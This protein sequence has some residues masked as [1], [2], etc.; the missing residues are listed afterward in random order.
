MIRYLSA[1]FRDSRAVGIVLIACTLVSLL[2]ANTIF[3]H[4]WLGFLETPLTLPFGHFPHTLLH[5]IN[6]GAMALFFFLAGLDIRKEI[7]T[8]ALSSIKKSMLPV[9][10]AAGGMLCPAFIFLLFNHGTEGVHGWGIPMATDIA[11]SLGILSLL[12]KRVPVEL[13]VFLTAL[14][15]IDDLG[16]ILTI[17]IFYT[18]QL[19]LY[20]LLGAAALLLLMA[21]LRLLKIK[22]LIWYVIPGL[23]L[24]YCIFNSGIHATIAGVLLAFMIPGKHIERLLH[25]LHF[26]VTFIIMPAFAL[27]NTAIVFPNDGLKALG[28]M[29]SCGLIAGL[30][31]GKP[32]GIMSFS[33][34]AARLGLAELPTQIRWRQLL[35]AGIIA[36]IGFTMSIF[37]TTLAYIDT[38]LQTVSKMAV[39]TASFVAGV[40]GFIYLRRQQ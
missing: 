10:A 31:I 18:S 34:I 1:F 3:Q 20:Y 35:G 39:I 5:W 38:T 8:G 16:A 17:A 21:G 13:R 37:I 14:A 4:A 29:V 26:P 7:S 30:V 22:S 6:D 15:I 32:L 19:A 33:Y 36:G 28:N 23:L 12:G 2:L 9:L 25:R 40:T 24:W 11:F 27:A